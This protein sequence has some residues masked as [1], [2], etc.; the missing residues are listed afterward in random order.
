MEWFINEVQTRDVYWV[1]VLERLHPNLIM[2]SE[3]I[4]S[5][6][7]FY[8]QIDWLPNNDLID[9]KN[10]LLVELNT[11]NSYLDVVLS[12][13]DTILS[14]LWNNE[15]RQYLIVFQN[16]DEIRPTGWFMWSMAIA[17]MF[18]G[19]V[20]IFDKKDVYAIEWDL[21]LADY[22]RR[23][24]PKWI[25]ELTEFF[26]LRDSNY[27]INTRDSAET[28]QFFVEQAWLEIDGVIFLN[29]NSILRLLDISGPVYFDELKR[30]ITKNNFSQI[31]SLLVE[32]KVFHVGTLGTPKQVLFDFVP[33]FFTH[34]K[35]E[36]RYSEYANFLIDEIQNREVMLWF[37]DEDGQDLLSEL[38]IDG[39]IDFTHS[40]D[41]WYPVYT[42]VSW[43]K[44]DRYMQ[45][46]YS[47]NITWSESCDYNIDVQISSTH[48][49]TKVHRDHIATLKNDFWI[50]DDD[51]LRFIQWEGR[52]RQF[53][54]YL[55]PL[56]AQVNQVQSWE[57]VN[58]GSRQGVEFFLE[59]PLLQTSRF[60]FSYTLSN[61]DCLWYD[62]VHY[63]QPGIRKYDIDIN[64]N[65]DMYRYTDIT[66]DF[67]FEK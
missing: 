45:R 21:K 58:Y 28:I 57:V 12:H 47:Y 31:I 37:F 39:Q 48:A 52:N 64:Y 32:A 15:R 36:W 10:Q 16:A 4:K 3:S 26:W 23:P 46:S 60:D 43:N 61:P 13:Y 27:F 54:R 6:I 24:A 55:L 41:F 2:I 66:S 18:R 1:H 29:Q 49:M 11:W 19:R 7:Y 22:D 51:E 59:T 62:F 33:V 34:L 35:E 5:S 30:D 20:D 67:Y 53:V 17:S 9:K 42:S 44:S 25:N 38:W 56:K 8:E 63:K 14:H 40:K 65:G 50:E